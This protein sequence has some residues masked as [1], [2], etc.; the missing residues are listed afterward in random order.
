MCCPPIMI[1]SAGRHFSHATALAPAKINLCLRIAGVREDGYH[2]LDSVVVAVRIFDWVEIRV[3]RSPRPDVRL[4][5]QPPGAAPSG[6]DNLALR[7]A[8]LFAERTRWQRRIDLTLRKVIPSGAGLGG[9]SSDA[10]AVLRGLN[11]L[12]DKP[13]LSSQLAHWGLELGADVPFFLV[14]SAARMR[15]IGEQLE[16]TR[17]PLPVGQPIVVAFPR[18][19]L[20]TAEVYAH[21]DRSLTSGKGATS[22]NQPNSNQG[23]LRA[24]LRNDLEAAAFQLLPALPALKR[25]LCALGARGVLMTG[26]GSAVFGVWNRC[27]EARAAAAMLRGVGIWARATEILERIPAIEVND[28]RDGRSPSW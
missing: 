4:I 7:A 21:Y 27:C 23:P 28:T 1:D 14:G 12:T 17:S 13:V 8:M 25:Q 11:A 2:L 15:G 6:R 20:S 9:G 5:C 10:A 3:E 19:G 22:M 26:S 24:W 16:P 18:L